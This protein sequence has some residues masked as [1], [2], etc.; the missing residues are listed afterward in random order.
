MLSID[1]EK[2]R[3]K[4]ISTLYPAPKSAGELGP[5]IA[6]VKPS[7]LKIVAKQGVILG[8]ITAIACMLIAFFLRISI[9][10]TGKIN[11]WAMLIIPLGLVVM[12]LVIIGARSVNQRLDHAVMYTTGIF[13]SG[14][15]ATVGSALIAYMVLFSGARPSLGEWLIKLAVASISIVIVTTAVMLIVG[16]LLEKSK[17]TY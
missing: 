16:K 8:T 3:G 13:W 17:P 6:H 12:L 1:E 7:D 9:D 4:E 14:F 5:H 15:I 10:P 11:Q 2:A